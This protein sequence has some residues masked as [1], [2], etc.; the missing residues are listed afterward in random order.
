MSHGKRKNVSMTA[1][2]LR[3]LI[4]ERDVVLVT[5]AWWP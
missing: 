4:D 1:N 3:A 2:E 5:P